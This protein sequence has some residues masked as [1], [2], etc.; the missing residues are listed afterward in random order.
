MLPPAMVED[1]HGASPVEC[2]GHAMNVTAEQQRTFEKYLPWILALLAAWVVGRGL[3]KMFW[4]LFGL[5]WMMW[6]T[7]GLH[8]LRDMF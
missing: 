8:W 3:R 2:G 1:Q 5:A 4:T 7:G 6:W